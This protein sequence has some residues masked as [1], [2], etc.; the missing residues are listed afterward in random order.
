M[1]HAMCGAQVRTR[2][3]R[4]RPEP[5]RPRP[6]SRRRRRS[7]V[8]WSTTGSVVCR[9]TGKSA[10]EAT[11]AHVGAVVGHSAARAPGCSRTAA[12]RRGRPHWKSSTR[13]LSELGSKTRSGVSSSSRQSVRAGGT[14]SGPRWSCQ[15]WQRL[16]EGHPGDPRSTPAGRRLA[17]ARTASFPCF[18]RVLVRSRPAGVRRQ[19]VQA[20]V[21]DC[22]ASRPLRRA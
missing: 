5:P 10:M 19:T 18:D 20:T 12:R 1:G 11:R 17:T 4:R 6:R 13:L 8:Q 9:G 3:V 7:Q 2:L 16:G 21:P 15:G 14:L 22:Q